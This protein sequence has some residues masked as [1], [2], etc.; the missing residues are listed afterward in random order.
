MKYEL[1]SVIERPRDAAA[2]LFGDC[3]RIKEWL[4]GLVEYRHLSGEPGQPGAK[5][6]LVLKRITVVKTVTNRN[7]PFSCTYEIKKC[8]ATVEDIFEELSPSSTKWT[9][10]AELVFSGFMKIVAG[11]MQG[12]IKS[13]I[14]KCMEAFKKFAEGER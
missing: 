4:P 10:R 14:Y 1:E 13:E 9:L 11:G 12:K 8:C 6:E 5:A 7:D 3:S 2:D